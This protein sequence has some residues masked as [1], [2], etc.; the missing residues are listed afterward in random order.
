MVAGSVVGI[1]V[2][3]IMEQSLRWSCLGPHVLQT[4]PVKTLLSRSI[5][6]LLLFARLDS[7]ILSGN[8]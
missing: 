4:G 5:A 1:L 8:F 6:L 7:L 3:S 2:F